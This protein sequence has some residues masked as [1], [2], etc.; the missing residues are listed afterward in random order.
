MHFTNAIFIFDNNKI[1]KYTPRDYFN[2]KNLFATPP[3][4]YNKKINYNF[5][6]NSLEDSLYFFIN[7][8]KNKN[9]FSIKK[10]NNT[11]NA[12]KLFLD[13]DRKQ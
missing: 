10:F 5:I 12:N 3:S 4:K 2:K 6:N 8:V 7:N 9:S 13:Y 1:K 11:I